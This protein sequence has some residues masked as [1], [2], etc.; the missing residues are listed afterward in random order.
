[1]AFQNGQ[2]EPQKILTMAPLSF[3]SVLESLALA[4]VGAV[5]ALLD[6]ISVLPVS[7]SQSFHS[8]VSIELLND[9][10]VRIHSYKYCN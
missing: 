4:G 3:D 2:K 5:P 8:R 10:L 7:R 1:M 6:P 9:F